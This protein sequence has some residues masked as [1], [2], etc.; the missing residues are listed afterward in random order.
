[1]QILRYIYVF[2]FLFSIQFAL[3]AQGSLEELT[4]SYEQSV[5]K[6]NK[7]EIVSR[8]QAIANYHAKQQ[9]FKKAINFFTQA[10]EI[11]IPSKNYTALIQIYNS[12]G[13]IFYQLKQYDN[14]IPY[15]KRSEEAANYQ[16]SKEDQL[17]AIYSIAS[18]LSLLKRYDESIEYAKRGE[19]IANETGNL[20]GVKTAYSIL[21]GCY[22][23]KND[24]Q[25]FNKYFT[26]YSE[27][28][29][30]IKI[31]NEAENSKKIK[32]VETK[33]EEVEIENKAKKLELD[34][35]NIALKNKQDS[36][37]RTEEENEKN[38]KDIEKLNKEKE[39]QHK[40]V[41]QQNDIIEQEKT[42][43]K[44]I[45][46]SLGVVGIFLI[47]II[48]S[49]FLIRKSNSKLNKQNIE[50]K[51]KS[52]QIQIQSEEI[53]LKS[54][55]L[56]KAFD[57]ITYQNTQIKDSINYALNIQ[58]AIL[59]SLDLFNSNLPK[60]FVLFQPRDVVS[61][62]IYWFADL[63]TEDGSE[64]F[65]VAAVDCTGHGVP[66]ALMSMIALRL[67]EEVRFNKIV[68]PEIMLNQM[69][70]GIRITLRQETTNNRDGMDMSLCV[71]NKTTKELKFA[72]A[73]N[74]LV[75]VENGEVKKIIADKKSIGGFHP[76]NEVFFNKTT[77]PITS[78]LTCYLFSDGYLDQLGHIGKKFTIKGM[79]AL[80]GQ[81]YHKSM[82]DQLEIF[83][84]NFVD[85][86]GPNHQMDD[87]LLMGFV[88]D[89][90][91]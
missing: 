75:Y 25:N 71:I 8:L 61:G 20:K 87:V 39:L 49:L 38:Q 31:L 18:S 88:V 84:K 80:V 1:M 37:R 83:R 73:R 56:T 82:A 74:P 65:A 70:L 6:G 77:I 19:K 91:N 57:K 67:L 86:S 30:K 46:I 50:I 28:D 53:S 14:A 21:A 41:Q 62:D 13:K 44:I 10:E 79:E 12:I 5:A 54:V 55:E 29:K 15:F 16:K 52:D 78:P 85:F 32:A 22:Q 89:L 72:G 9:D 45:Y 81:S 90:N 59:P 58:S 64:Q 69:H 23:D 4:K 63:L 48:R 66:G 34:L 51:E 2:L 60:N 26:L 35:K 43:R 7:Y 68:E 17:V 47:F 27:I 36:L 42:I 40:L 3:L 33:V 76:T 11:A 24:Q